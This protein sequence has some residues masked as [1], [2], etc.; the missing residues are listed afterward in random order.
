[1]E[2][3]QT[4]AGLVQDLKKE[5]IMTEDKKYI[6]I[7]DTTLRDGEQSPGASMNPQEKV[8]IARQLER[9]GV[10]AIEAGFPISSEGDAESVKLVAKSVK[11]CQI[12]ALSRTHPADVEAAW[13]AVRHA[14]A[15]AIHVFIATSPV[16]MKRKLRMKPDQ[17]FEEAVQ[18]VRLAKK[19]APFVEFSAEDATRSDPDFLCRI[20]QGVLEAG[21]D[22]INIPDTVGYTVPDEYG[23]L[24][25]RIRERVDNID[26]AIISVHC[27]NDLGL[28]VANTLT[29]VDHGARQV[30]CTINGIGERA[31]N[32][33]L[34]EVVTAPRARK[35]Y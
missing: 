20:F 31:G 2:A 8:E 1:M 23:R 17:V 4:E 22:C 10:D 33:S 34:E 19:F 30:E 14:E 35:G 28:A 7:F 16:H 32:C 24:I 9:L 5:K 25:D 27:H 11:S 18:A 6:R 21:A 12:V 13:E 29:A 26:K 3:R 15:P